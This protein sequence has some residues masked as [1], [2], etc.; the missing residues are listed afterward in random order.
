MTVHDPIIDAQNYGDDYVIEQRWEAYT[1][2][3]HAVWRTLYERQIE[4]LNGRAVPEFYD[5]LKALNLN[6]G[7]IPDLE[8]LNKSLQAL[9]GWSVVCVPHLIPA[10]LRQGRSAREI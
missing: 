8:K 7:G 10:G 9:T 5:G 1:A 2:E 3:E 4:V 6:D